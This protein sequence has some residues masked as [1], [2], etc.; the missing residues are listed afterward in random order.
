MRFR[1]ILLAYFIMGATL[2]GGGV[3]ALDEADPIRTVVSASG[4]EIKPNDE[5]A[6]QIKSTKGPVE[7]AVKNF[8]GGGLLAVIGLIF[9]ALSFMFWPI[10]VLVG[11]GAPPIIVLLMGGIPTVVFYGAVLGVF[12]RGA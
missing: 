2:Y 9:D 5:R 1:N 3:I 10:V 8:G 7:E 6:S 4:G 12:R 11:L